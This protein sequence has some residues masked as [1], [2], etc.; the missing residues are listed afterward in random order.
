MGGKPQHKHQEKEKKKASY[1]MIFWPEHAEDIIYVYVVN[2]IF[3]SVS[4]LFVRNWLFDVFLHYIWVCFW[5]ICE[6]RA[7]ID[8]FFHVDIS[9][10]N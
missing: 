2:Q 5:L 3:E 10:V 7:V 8:T 6:T 9:E 4:D 1:K